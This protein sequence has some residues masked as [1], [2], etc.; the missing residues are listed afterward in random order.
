LLGATGRGEAVLYLPLKA[1]MRTRGVLEVAMDAET[2][3]RERPLLDTVASLAALTLERLHYVEVAQATEVRMASERLRAS[4]LSSLSHDLRTPLTALV[5]LADTLAF[6]ADMPEQHRETARALRNQALRLSGMVTNLLD[7]ARL[8]A[9]GVTPRKD[10]HSLE[11]VIGSAIQWLGSALDAHPIAVELPADMPLLE[12]DPLLLE[13]VLGNLLDNAV[14]YSPPGRPITI[15]A[16]LLEQRAEVEV[17]DGGP[18]YPPHAALAE[19]FSR[20]EAES[21]QPGVGLGLAICKV[22]VEAHGGALTLDNPP[23]GGARARFTCP[24][25]PRPPLKRK[26]EHGPDR[27]GRAPYP[28]LRAPGPGGRRLPGAGGGSGERRPGAGR[29]REAGPGGAGPGPARR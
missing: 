8:S 29:G 23:E 10:W 9:G 11:E 15:A 16:R 20:G 12:F 6:P 2:L 18:G 4:I 22:I 24:W 19:A 28:P 7:L 26:H 3:H 14:K 5:G 21:A 13:R 17:R 1:P 25:A 27:R